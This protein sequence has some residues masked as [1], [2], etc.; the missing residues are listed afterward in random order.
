MWT[1]P[2]VGR[3]GRAVLQ[4]LAEDEIGNRRGYVVRMHTLVDGGGIFGQHTED[5][6]Q[7]VI[8]SLGG[9]YCDLTPRVI[10][11]ESE[12]E[13]RP[14]KIA[15][16]ELAVLGELARQDVSELTSNVELVRCDFFVWHRC[17]FADKTGCILW[18]SNPSPLCVIFAFPFLW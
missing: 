14:W 7:P 12:P 16:D 11:L 6:V 5:E 1:C 2:H 10:D 15:A 3:N 17:S 8:V 13:G 9:V 4:H 18:G